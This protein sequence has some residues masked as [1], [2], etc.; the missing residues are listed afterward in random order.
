MVSLRWASLAARI[1]S[2][3]G[4]RADGN[5]YSDKSLAAAKALQGWY[6]APSGLWSTTGWWNSANCLT[7]LTDW[8]LLAESSAEA[9]DV[10]GIIAN[11]FRNA[12]QTTVKSHRA[13]SPRGMTTPS[14]YRYRPSARKRGFSEFINDYYDDEG[15]WALALIRAWDLTREQAYLAMAERVFA[16]MHNGTDGTC[17]GGLWWSKERAYKNA[18]ANELY[19]SVAASLANRVITSKR[20]QYTQLARDSW[21]WFRGSGMINER[22][23]VNDGLRIGADGRCVNNGL[24]T[25]S[26]N[27][28]VVLGGLVELAQA[29]GDASYLDPAVAIA[30]AALALLSGDGDGDGIIREVNECEPDC[31]ADGSQFKGIFVRNLGY[32]HR[33]APHEA[34]RDAIVRNAD[35]IW[36]RNRNDKNQLGIKWTGPPELGEG[37]NASTHSSAMDVIVAALAVS[38]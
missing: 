22:D 5:S 9:V 35:S 4:P 29:T 26:Y 19:L 14:S 8:A 32:L 33:A 17:G 27:Q 28:G 18:I 24:P 3:L 15:W 30:Q 25:W 31:G 7:V 16:D 34:F 1:A 10:P 21:T 20:A 36:A 6:N 13:V 37:P 38:S 12:Q 2:T 11:T 23:L